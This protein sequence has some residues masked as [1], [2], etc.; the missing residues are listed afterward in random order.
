MGFIS[1]KIPYEA[2][3]A[4]RISRICE[5]YGVWRHQSPGRSHP[6]SS[7]VLSSESAPTSSNSR[8]SA[9]RPLR[10]RLTKTQAPMM[11]QP[12]RK[13]MSAII[14]SAEA[15][16]ASRSGGELDMRP[17]PPDTM[18]SDAAASSA[19]KLVF[20]GLKLRRSP[21]RGSVA[22]GSCV[23]RR[24]RWIGKIVESLLRFCR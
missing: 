22:S 18:A 1:R 7:G 15:S 2:P 24:I 21:F 12:R 14:T 23:R 11:K 5:D 20:G 17:S 13:K 19:P 9:D 4:S 16:E 3:F 10:S 8:A 6:S